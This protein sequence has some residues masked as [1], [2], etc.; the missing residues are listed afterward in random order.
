VRAFRLV[1]LAFAAVVLDAALAPEIEIAGARPDFLVLAIVYTSLVMGARAATIT[2]FA[3]GLAA[4]AAMP[5]YLGLHAL[6]LSATAFAVSALWSR[7]VRTNALVQCMVLLAGSLMHDAIYYIAY[8]RNHL[9]LFGRF[10]LRF[11]VP[12][13]LYTAALG[14][15]VY[16][17]ALARNWRAIAGGARH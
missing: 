16:F 9:D 10:L 17:I 7:L 13:G 3:I 1:L 2:G 14:S 8:Y 6:S 12:G 15:I 4:D 11:G 5:E